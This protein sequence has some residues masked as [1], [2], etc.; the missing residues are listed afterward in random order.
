MT[1]PIVRSNP[2]S[3]ALTWKDIE[4]HQYRY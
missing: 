1:L 3:H 2:A 4:K